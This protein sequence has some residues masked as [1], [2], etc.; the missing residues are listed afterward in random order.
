MPSENLFGI[1]GLVVIFRNTCSVF[2]LH[3]VL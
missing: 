1:C 2:Y 3:L